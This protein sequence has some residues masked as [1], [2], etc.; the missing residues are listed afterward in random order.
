[1]RHASEYVPTREN[2]TFMF[3]KSIKKYKLRQVKFAIIFV[4]INFIDLFD[5]LHVAVCTGV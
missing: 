5:F 1:M 4:T 3:I 2:I